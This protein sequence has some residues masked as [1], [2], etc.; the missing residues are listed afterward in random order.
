MAPVDRVALGLSIAAWATLA[1][2][3]HP[4]PPPSTT[5]ATL[6]AGEIGRVG[7]VSLPQSLV[8]DVS[9]AQS[10]PVRAA[11]EVLIE[12]ALAAQAALSQHLMDRPSVQW[13]CTSA[14]ARRVPIRLAETA[15]AAGPP[16]D[17]ELATLKVVH[18]VVQRSKGLSDRAD[19]A[20]AMAIEQAVRSAA[21]ADDFERL[22]A[23]VPHGEARVTIERI[24]PFGAEGLMAD[25]RQLDRAF[26]AAAFMLDPST[27]SSAT[28]PVVETRFGWHVIRL[29]ERVLPERSSIEERRQ[30]LSAAVVSMRARASLDSLLRLR[31]RTTDVSVAAT[32]EALTALAAASS[33]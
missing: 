33:P 19:Q 16:T 10:V 26:V 3:S 18:A 29:I 14:I 13:A 30:A 25:G 7:D 4:S 15:K 24:L 1:A 5:V 27:I 11:I 32:A 9:R 17:N 8:V 20:V 21:N 23:A 28:S 31:R 2:C 12:D 6:H 22:A